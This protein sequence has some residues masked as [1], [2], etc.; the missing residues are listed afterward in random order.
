MH[1]F[2]PAALI[3]FACALAPDILVCGGIP[4]ECE[5]ALQTHGIA[6]IW[7]V[8]GTVDQ[9]IRAVAEGRLDNDDAVGL[10]RDARGCLAGCDARTGEER[11]LPRTSAQSAPTFA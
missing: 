11:A 6:V 1:N 7:G 4:P 8:I 10:G 9:V 2:E 3:D 5:Q